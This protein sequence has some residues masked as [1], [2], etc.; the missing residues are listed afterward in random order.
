M[1]VPRIAVVTGG[2]G[3][4]GSHL[5]D[6]LLG[7]GFRVHVID[8]LV[9]G[10]LE[11]LAHQKDDPNLVVETRDILD[12]D[13]DDKLFAGI[14][15]VFHFAGIGD[16]VPSIDKPVEYLSTNVMGTV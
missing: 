6:L 12:L 14:E 9:G 2:A 8:N 16:I 4:I 13:P 1:S 10:R 7:E 11:N 5:V 3:F 15:Y